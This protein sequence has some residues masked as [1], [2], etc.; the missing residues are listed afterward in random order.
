M[1][2]L[3]DQT[4]RQQP[5]S[6]SD[7]VTAALAKRISQHASMHDL[8]EVHVILHGGEPLMLGKRRLPRWVKNVENRV[9][10]VTEPIFSAQ[11]N[12]ILLDREWVDILADANVAIGISVDGP[13]KYHDQFRLDHSGRG[14]YDA[15]V[16]AI[17]ALQDHPRG[18]RV[19]SSVLA[20]VNTNI[21]PE[22]MFEF[23]E[24][25]DVSGFD[26]SLPHANHVHQ[27]PRGRVSYGDWMIQFF[28]L[29]FAQNRADRH[30]RYFENILRMLFGYPISTDNIG[31]KPVGVVVIETDG[32]IEPTDAF[33]CCIHGI[34]KLGMSVVRNEF[35]DLYEIPMVRVLQH[36]APRLCSECQSCDAVEVCGGGYMPH[37]YS[38][39]NEFENP[40]VYCDDIY[41]LVLHIRQKAIGALPKSLADRLFAPH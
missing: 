15:V 33:K 30:V 41:K 26:F 31:G 6:M 1:Y 8:R 3:A 34:T 19:F 21:P 38:L 36:G 40:T 7:E 9:G 35:D 14:S 4:Y 2:N 39:K 20:V 12:G 18:H 32:S 13:R 29:W 17:R 23:W 24:Y 5:G 37:R 25:L 10:N 16:R 22:E 28:D 27:P 11:S